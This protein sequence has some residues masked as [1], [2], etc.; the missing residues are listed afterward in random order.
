[1]TV[2]ES[3][4]LELNCTSNRLATLSWFKRNRGTNSLTKIVPTSRISITSRDV[5]D[6]EGRTLVA[7]SILAIRNLGPLDSGIYVCEAQDEPD[8]HYANH[9]VHINGKSNY[10]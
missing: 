3:E 6:F 8:T 10:D 5:D 9:T 7:Y 4:M 1:M 2:S